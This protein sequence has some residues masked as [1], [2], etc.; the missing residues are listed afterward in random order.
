MLKEV[1]RPK[2]MRNICMNAHPLGCQKNVLS[3]IEYV[4]QQ[5]TL[6]GGPKKVLILGGSAG[7]GLATRIAATYGYG[8]KTLNIAY[9]FP[10]V[11]AKKRPATVGWYNTKYFEEQ[12]KKD[13]YWAESILGD[14]F[15]NEIKAETIAKI[16]EELGTVDMVVY[17]LAS[18]KRQN[19]SDGVLYSS[20]LKPLGNSFTGQT[21]D[22]VTNKISELTVE[23]ANEKEC[24]DTVKVMG[25]EDWQLW[26]DALLEA[27]VLSENS[28]SVAYSYIGPQLTYPLYRSGTIG[29]AKEDLEKTAHDIDM[30]MNAKGK[31][32]AY[33]SVNKALVTRASM[34]IPVVPLYLSL[35]YKV[36]KREGL[37][38]GCIEQMYRMCKE[39]IYNGKAVLTDTEQRIRLD[40][41]EMK[42]DIQE[43]IVKLWNSVNEDTIADIADLVGFKK[44][45]YNIHGFEWDDIDYT[46][47]VVL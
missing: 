23:P 15:S 14:A 47:A 16:K 13:G 37:H 44:E 41:W 34:V 24:A 39:K 8:A 4:K 10:A 17:S 28:I 30:K 42:K 22:V 2:I 3:Q 5:G 32:R 1:I 19:P 20:V 40:D 7:Y 46:Q 26:I 35:L 27:E 18:G 21:I 25:G 31:G 43:E 6:E 36:M 29:K 33:V 9:E 12:A 38:E 45:F 11:E